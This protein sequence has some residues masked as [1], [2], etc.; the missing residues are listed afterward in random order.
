MLNA[1]KNL[2]KVAAIAA[3]HTDPDTG[4]LGGMLHCVQDERQ[5][6]PRI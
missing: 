6:Y 1:A 2:F 4:C 3:S 5:G